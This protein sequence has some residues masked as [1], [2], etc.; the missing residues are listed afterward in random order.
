MRFAYRKDKKHP[1]VVKALRKVGA[2]V[3]NLNGK[4]VPDLVCV[5]RGRVLFLEV[6][7][8][9]EVGGA[10]DKRTGRL[11]KS[12]GGKVSEGQAD[13]HAAWRAAGA[14][15]EVVHDPEEALRVLFSA[16]APAAND[17]GD[18]AK[19]LGVSM[20]ATAR[21]VAR[22]LTGPSMAALATSATLRP[23]ARPVCAGCKASAHD[24][25]WDKSCVCKCH[26]GGQ[27]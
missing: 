11:R 25:P 1:D 17:T 5:Y 13:W 2:L 8:R 26:G 21:A 23:I 9:A 20:D 10:L 7:T 19:A 14:C 12:R 22:R 6:K 18:T 4:D 24:G 27:P 15:V 16:S 3:Q